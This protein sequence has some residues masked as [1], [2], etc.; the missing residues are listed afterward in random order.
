MFGLL[1]CLILP[2]QPN[3][4]RVKKLTTGEYI[5]YCAHCNGRIRRLNR[6]R[7]VRDWKRTFGGTRDEVVEE[8]CD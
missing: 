4:R 3:R 7:W 8:D 1:R 5:G 6:D 2:H